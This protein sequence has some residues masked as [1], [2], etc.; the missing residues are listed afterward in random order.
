MN[1]TRLPFSQIISTTLIILLSSLLVVAQQNRGTLRGVI[2]DELG[3]VIVGANVVLTD[4]SGVQKKTTTNAEG[5]YN[6]AGLPPGKYSLQANA[7]GF[8]PSEDKQVDVT[9][10]RQTL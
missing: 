9:A 1:P 4:A 3:A 10:G 5:V 7:P 2:S 8:A 6:Y